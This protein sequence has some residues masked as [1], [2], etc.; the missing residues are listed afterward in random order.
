MYGKSILSIWS[1][2]TKLHLDPMVICMFQVHYVSFA[3]WFVCFL[4]FFGLSMWWLIVQLTDSVD[5]IR[6]KGT[7]CSQEVAI[8]VLKPE[9]IDSD[10]QREFAQEVFIMRY[11]M[12]YHYHLFAIGDLFLLL[13]WSDFVE[14]LE[15]GWRLYYWTLVVFKRLA[16]CI[17]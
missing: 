15:S 12:Q 5:S 14:S 9:R 16:F 13:Q 7:Y 10:M 17:S 8:K 4:F 6:Y 11:Y 2:R 1:L 3:A